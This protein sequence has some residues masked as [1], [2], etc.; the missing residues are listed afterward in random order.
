VTRISRIETSGFWLAMFFDERCLMMAGHVFYEWFL[1]LFDRGC[2]AISHPRQA[3]M[4][5]LTIDD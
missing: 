3:T 4:G 2:L 1:T 5:K